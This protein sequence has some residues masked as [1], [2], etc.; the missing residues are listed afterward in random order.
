TVTTHQ[1]A[2]MK[3]NS[4]GWLVAMCIAPS[5]Q[6][7]IKAETLVFS[8]VGKMDSEIA[9]ALKQNIGQFNIESEEEL[10][11]INEIAKKQGKIANIAIRINPDIDAKTHPKISTGL[12]NNKFGIAY[13]QA[14]ELFKQAKQMEAI[15]ASSIAIHIGS[16][17]MTLDPLRNAY[18]R[19][20]DFYETLKSNAI[21]ITSLDIGGG[22]G[23]AYHQNEYSPSCDDWAH[24]IHKV[25]GDLPVKIHLEPG[26]SIVGNSG[27]LL[28]R[29]IRI[30]KQYGKNFAILDCAMNDLMRPALYESYHQ[31]LHIKKENSNDTLK[32]YDV[33]GPICE[34]TDCF[35]RDYICTKLTPNDLVCF[36]HAGA[37][38]AVMANQYN[39]RPLIGEILING[40]NIINAKPQK[41]IQQEIDI[42]KQQNWADIATLLNK[43]EP[44]SL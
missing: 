18:H 44:K 17:I 8:G 11:A 15:Q 22:V 35:L 5:Q 29:V 23:I 10:Y 36:T 32:R 21:P 14:I 9:A 37:Y 33:V 7:G 1:W 6:A 2:V 42:E 19:L 39:S 28:S 20:R 24:L 13:P 25:L 27:V 41:N 26:R 31:M 3:N 40:S 12:R 4:L 30:K 43:N 38:S 16:Q 34:S